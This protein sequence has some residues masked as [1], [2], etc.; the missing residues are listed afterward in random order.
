MATGGTESGP[1]RETTL[2]GRLRG[3]LAQSDDYGIVL[4]LILATIFT[5]SLGSGRSTLR[6]SASAGS[7][8][9]SSSIHPVPIVGTYLVATAV[10]LVAVVGAAGALLTGAAWGSD[11]TALVGLLLAFAAPVV[12]LRRVPA[13]ADHHGP[14][15]PGGA[16]HL[17]AARPDVRVPVSVDPPG[18]R[19]TVLRPDDLAAIDRLDVY[20]SYVTLTTV[21][22]GDFTAST[23]V[24]RMM[25]GPEALIGQLYLVSAVALLVGNVGR[26]MGRRG[27]VAGTDVDSKDHGLGRRPLRTSGRLSISTARGRRAP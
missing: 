7:R 10:V 4:L 12:I 21:G 9:S 1:D 5:L 18:D 3:R 2:G 11:A 8:C 17:P 13:V 24:G 16:R 6:A 23:S 26:T 19:W 27:P 15:G 14:A 22:Y 20:F 25:A